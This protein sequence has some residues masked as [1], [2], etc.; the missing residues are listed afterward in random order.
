MWIHHCSYIHSPFGIEFQ[1]TQTFSYYTIIQMP[2]CKLN[3]ICFILE[4]QN[5]LD[6]NAQT[7]GC[8]KIITELDMSHIHIRFD[9]FSLHPEAILHSKL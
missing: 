8:V 1:I 2:F 7:N 9:S 6:A 4:Y 5:C 3:F